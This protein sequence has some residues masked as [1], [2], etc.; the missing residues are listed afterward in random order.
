MKWMVDGWI[1]EN[2]WGG[3]K[4]W[5]KWNPTNEMILMHGYDSLYNPPSMS[6]E[7]IRWNG[8]EKIHGW[9]D[10]FVGCY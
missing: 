1:S 8:H 4:L 9:Y 10:I 3:S 5:M 6:A 2:G 7:P